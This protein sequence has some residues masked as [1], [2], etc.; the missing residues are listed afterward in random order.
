ML[1]TLAASLF[2]LFHVF[3]W[4]GYRLVFPGDHWA[5]AEGGE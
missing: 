5:A 1:P 2:G 4:L 3:R